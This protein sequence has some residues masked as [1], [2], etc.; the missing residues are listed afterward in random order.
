MH[1]RHTNCQYVY[2]IWQIKNGNILLGTTNHAK[3][4][5][6]FNVVAVKLYMTEVLCI[7]LMTLHITFAMIVETNFYLVKCKIG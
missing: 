6:D 5:N 3:F 7:L 1:N 2:L 4:K